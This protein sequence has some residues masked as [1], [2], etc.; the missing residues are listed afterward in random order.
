MFNLRKSLTVG[1][2]A[3]TVFVMSGLASVVSAASAQPGDLVKAAG[4]KT[5]YYLG[6]DSKLYNIPNEGTYFSWYKDWSGVITVSVTD[7]NSYGNGIPAGFVTMRPGTNLIQRDVTTDNTVY[8]VEPG[9]VLRTLTTANAIALYGSAWAKKV[10]KVSDQ[11][12]VSYHVTTA[13]PTSQYPIGSLLKKTT[14]ADVYYFDGTNYR[15][16]ATAAAFNANRFNS[17][18]VVKTSMNFTA[19]GTDITGVESNLI[20]AAQNG[21]TINTN[22][23]VITGSG[24]TVSMNAN[25]AAST[26]LVTTTAG[27]Q[28]IADMATFNF[29]AANDGAITVKTM[30]LKRIGI[31]S[32]STLA[33]VYLYN[34]N[35]KLTDAGSLSNGYVTF[36]NGNGLF[37][38]PAG[39]TLAISVK[40]DVAASATGN[41]GFSINSASDITSTGAVTTGG[42]PLS[43]NLMSIVTATDLATVTI[44]GVTG[45]GNINAGTMNTTLWSAPLTVSNKAVDLKYVSFRQIGSVASDAIQNLKLYVDGVQVGGSVSVSDNRVIFD[46]TSNPVRMNTGSRT[47][48]LRGDIVK[49][50]N[51][52]FSFSVQTPSDI[53]LV[54]TNYSVN[55]SAAGTPQTTTSASINNGSLV[56]SADATFAATQVV[57][58]SSNVT[59][60]KYT[61]K[62]YGEDMKVTTLNA[63]VLF[64]NNV[65]LNDGIQNLSLYVNGSQV[66]SS[67]NA[68]AGGTVANFTATKTYGTTNLFTIPAGTTATV[69]VRGDLVMNNVSTT[70]DTITTNVAAATGAYQGVISFATTP[71]SP[72]T[73]ATK[74]LSIVSTGLATLSKNSGFS[75]TQTLSSNVQKQKIGSFTLQAGSSEAVRFTNYAVKLAVV[76]SGTPAMTINDVS[77]LYT[78][79]DAT[80]VIGN[81]VATPSV[82]NFPVNFTLQPGQ[83]KT[84][85]VYADIAQ[86]GNNS[87]L[88]VSDLKVSARTFTTNLTAD[89]NTA[90]QNLTFQT[91]TLANPVLVTTDAPA[92]LVIGGTSDTAAVYKFVAT[93]GAAKI[94]SMKVKVTN[95]AGTAEGTSVNSLTIGS[96]TAPVVYDGSNYVAFFD[97]TLAID[98]PVSTIGTN[99][100]VT[101]N[102]NTV[103]TNATVT[104][105]ESKLTATYVKYQIGTNAPAEMTGLTVAGNTMVVTAAKPTVTLADYTP[106]SHVLNVG[107]QEALRFTVSAANGPVNFKSFAVTPLFNGITGTTTIQGVYDINDMGTNL[108]SAPVT[109]TTN[110]VAPI[111]L[112][113]DSLIS[114]ASSKTYV[115][116][117]GVTTLGALNSNNMTLNL[118]SAD[119]LG[120]GTNWQWNDTTVGTY[121]NGYLV[122]TLP[123]NGYSL[124]Y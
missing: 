122:K 67:Q 20:N 74:Q 77:N 103:G 32:D 23:N 123:V 78:S 116:K 48:E 106:T 16:V 37:T 113:N 112:T 81:P 64:N 26:N 93:N 83:T 61:M 7:L 39:Q 114:A 58:G 14:G 109:L 87:T 38:V 52:N 85:D 69:E 79:E 4:A 118:T 115:V 120:A 5:V 105:T 3:L 96:V 97:G 46:L 110:T 94:T 59:L 89:V 70:A 45:S 91:G 36:S 63:T 22:P 31:S 10:T 71:A 55:V 104:R 124:T 30:K 8:A 119:T 9:G 50:S 51:T 49:G 13:L 12:F 68:V 44:G 56:V 34:G 95:N 98:V 43:G 82:N 41:V 62:A 53:V 33:N 57:K 76:G 28:S 66:G 86:V 121:G 42:F 11:N 18:Y 90:G 47:L 6:S 65:A 27:G 40:A 24:L 80:N 92:K 107:T 17:K 72:A 21:G 35:T 15:K 19:G 88:T 117:V 102:Y 2:M 84:I 108:I 54:D 60:A 99:V 101:A 29:T 75:A 1:V 25:T 100:T 111:A 73:Y